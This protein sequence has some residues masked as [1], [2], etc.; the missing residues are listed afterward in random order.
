[1]CLAADSPF[2]KT[3]G[4]FIQ[5]LRSSIHALPL[6]NDAVFY[7]GVDLSPREIEHME[8]LQNFYIPSFTSTSLDREKAYSKPCLL[9]IK[10]PY[11]CRAAC[12]VTP[13]LSQHYNEE[14][15]VLLS[16][17]YKYR[18]ERVEK[19]NSTQVITLFLDEINS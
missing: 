3:H 18:L 4:S 9:V 16:C 11:L 8:L 17:Y 1:M 2:L 14:K 6:L 7:R 13:E 10:T 5:Q 12:S 15:E 19:V